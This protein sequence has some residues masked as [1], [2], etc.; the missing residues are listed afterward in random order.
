MRKTTNAGTVLLLVAGIA[1]ATA[2]RADEWDLGTTPSFT[3]NTASTINA[4]FHG[5]QQLHDVGGPGGG[6][7]DQDWYFVASDQ[8]SSYQFVVDGMTGRVGLT[9]TTV[10]RLGSDGATV[11]ENGFVGNSGGVVSLAWLGPGAGTTTSLPSF[12]RIQG[13]GC[14]ASCFGTDRYRARF[15]D[16]TYTIPRFNNS[17]SQS[18]IFVI[19]NASAHPCTVATHFFDAAGTLLATSQAGTVNRRQSLVFNTAVSVPNQSGTARIVH[20][21][22]YGGLA[23]K[24]VAVEPSTGF[25]FDTALL[26]RPR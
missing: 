18:T 21:C 22:G 3:D 25:T 2:A 26:H 20:T 7:V 6:V 10:Q 14:G 9:N 1:R 4:M 5:A 13:A 19:Q 24:A 17:G 12:V 8:F 15:Y 16:T 23:G 11:L